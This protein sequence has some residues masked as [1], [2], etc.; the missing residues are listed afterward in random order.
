MNK[1]RRALS[2]GRT[3]LSD[4]RWFPFFFQRRFRRPGHRA[5]AVRLISSLRPG[6]SAG[7]ASPDA[8]DELLSQGQAELGLV[9][10]RA[11]C[12]EIRAHL[13]Q[14]PVQDQYR[15]EV[16]PWLPLA[17]GR[18]P[19]SHVGYHAHEDVVRAPRLLALANRPDIL[20]LVERFLGCRPTIAYL[21]AW[22]SYPTGLA[23]QQAENFHRDVDDWRFVKL[24]VYLTD[25]DEAHGPHVYVRNSADAAEARAIRRF[26][27]EEVREHFPPENIVSMTGEAG[28]AFLEN[29]YGM[30][31]GQPVREGHRL[32]FQAVYSLL[33]LPYGPTAPVIGGAE[34]AAVAGHALDPFVN[35]VYVAQNG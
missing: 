35:R 30:H 24:F 8:A 18:H 11:E 19:H 13:E 12:D 4:W 20:A 3:V 9:L 21:A 5:A 32:I 6:P 23:A 2:T 7:A 28:T 10:S 29:T 1:V 25:V 22:W 33:P 17:E 15:P 34:A 26:T 27:D 16:A 31:K 14:R